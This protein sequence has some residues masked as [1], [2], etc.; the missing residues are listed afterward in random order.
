MKPKPTSS[1]A[2]SPAPTGRT[3]TAQ[4]KE[5][6]DTALGH[7]PQNTPSP[8]GATE[9]VGTGKVPQWSTNTILAE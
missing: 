5:R 9:G 4:G 1:A 8:E 3:R 7:T 2:N 6:S